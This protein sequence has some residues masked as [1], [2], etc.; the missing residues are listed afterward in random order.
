MIKA[1][2]SGDTGCVSRY[3]SLVSHDRTHGL[4]LL[5]NKIQLYQ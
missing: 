4:Y 3:E 5:L 2:V 1:I